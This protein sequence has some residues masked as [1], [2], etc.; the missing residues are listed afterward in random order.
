MSDPVVAIQARA[1]AAEARGRDLE[2]LTEILEQLAE[3][4]ELRA[5]PRPNGCPFCE[6]E[7]PQRLFGGRGGM[8]EEP[9]P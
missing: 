3:A 8:A 6:R 9:V 7:R 2:E 5:G 1:E 4:A